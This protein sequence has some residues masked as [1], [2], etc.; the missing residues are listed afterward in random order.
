MVAELDK[1]SRGEEV[2]GSGQ[3]I[4]DMCIGVL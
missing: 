4:E 1:Q 3:L 2:S